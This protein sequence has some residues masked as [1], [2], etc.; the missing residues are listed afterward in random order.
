MKKKQLLSIKIVTISILYFFVFYIN[1]AN[2]EIINSNDY[3]VLEDSKMII[4]S[5]SFNAH[6]KSNFKILGN[7]EQIE[8]GLTII[9][10]N[11]KNEFE[12]KTFDTYSSEE[13]S[14][15]MVKVLS[16]MQK[17]NAF[18]AILA[19]DSAAKSLLKQTKKVL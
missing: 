19:H 14:G 16:N 17:N 12:F 2:A 4:N 1:T 8:R 10:L 7:T 15:E 6:K 3:I 18:F 13:A 9:H 5:Y 11:A